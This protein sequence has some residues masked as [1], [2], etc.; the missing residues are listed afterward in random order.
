MKCI[1]L[2][3][4]A[5]S[6][7]S[8]TA[9]YRLNMNFSGMG[10]HV[11]KWLYVRIVDNSSTQ[12]WEA[13]S[14]KTMIDSPELSVS[15]LALLSGA[16]YKIDF[17]IDLNGNGRYEPPPTDHAWRL[18]IPPVLDSV[19][20]NFAHNTDFTDIAFPNPSETT[21]SFISSEWNGT[22]TNKTF[23]TQGPGSANLQLDYV[24]QTIFGSITMEGAFGN[25]APITMTGT[26][27]FDPVLNT[28]TMTMDEPFSGTITFSNGKITGAI[29]YSTL[30]VVINID[31]NYG[32]NQILFDYRMSGAFDAVGW[33]VLN[34]TQTT[35]IADGSASTSTNFDKSRLKASA[36]SVGNVVQVDYSAEL[37]IADNIVVYDVVGRLTIPAIVSTTSGHA[38]LD[39]LGYTSGPYIAFVSVGQLQLA[40]MFFKGQW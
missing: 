12:V 24:N 31:G 37:G 20:I 26:G 9:Q 22:W 6:G 32:Y 27:P 17:F 19:T 15:I 10:P 28:A 33:Y 14:I 5:L 40:A 25:P 4:V 38:T 2:A 1:F 30:N 8:L 16:P 21:P 39:V 34:R 18:L 36:S 7:I 29:T 35:G 11:G 13:A 3:I 23:D